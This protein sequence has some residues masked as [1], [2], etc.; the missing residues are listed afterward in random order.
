[1]LG[2]FCGKTVQG[3]MIRS[4]VDIVVGV[5]VVVIEL[6]GNVGGEHG[7]LGGCRC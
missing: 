7:V 3:A 6:P 4:F 2:V 1:M 5:R